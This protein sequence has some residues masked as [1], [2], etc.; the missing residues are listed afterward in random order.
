MRPLRRREP[1]RRG[2]EL[3]PITGRRDPDPKVTVAVLV[4]RGVTTGEVSEPVDRLCGRV[5]AEV[6]LV[7]ERP[8]PIPGVEPSRLVVADRGPDTAPPCDVVIVPGGLGW[9]QVADDPEL[10]RWLREATRSA[11]AVLA[12]ST[13]SLL[14]ASI[15]LLDGLDATGH[16]LAEDDLAELG[17]HVR[18][19]R[20]ARAEG[21]R[22]VTA[23]GVLAAVRAIDEV[24]A[25]V[26]WSPRPGEDW[27]IRIGSGSEPTM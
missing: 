26:A 11:R 20:V 12:I 2:W 22:L 17:A 18:R 4:Y 9:R 6:V 14:L 19:D 15:G 21:G 10:A 5:A 13:G 25:H 23:A 8:G 27:R 24:A 16:W 7:G 1:P 3:D